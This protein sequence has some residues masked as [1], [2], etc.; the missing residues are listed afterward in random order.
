[1][2]DDGRV[3]ERD[4]RARRLMI[5]LVVVAAVALGLDLLTKSL[6]V[7]KLNPD[8]PIHVIGDTVQF[9][10]IRNSG[11]AFSMA[12]GQTWILTVVAIAVVA[13][14]IKFGRKLQ[15]SW[16]ALGLGLVLGGALGNLV[17]RIFRAPGPMRGHVVD[18]ISVGWWPVFNLADSAIVCGAVLLAALSIFGVEP[19]GTHRGHDDASVTAGTGGPGPDGPG[20]DGSGTDS[21][22]SP[23]AETDAGT[24][25][26][27]DE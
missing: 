5:L 26:G 24:R 1:M 8:D 11:A 13:A 25:R 27:E 18:F 21:A 12:T 9:V 3:S 23:G 7:A 19:N 20:P 15:S 4:A 14:I 2:G 10:L 17:D 22:G 16:W 6:V